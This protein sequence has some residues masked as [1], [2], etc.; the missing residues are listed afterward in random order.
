V[1]Y[2]SFLL[3]PSP[4]SSS[5]FLFLQKKGG[6]MAGS[7]GMA[8]SCTKRVHEELPAEGRDHGRLLRWEA[9]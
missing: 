7:R 6:S 4:P 3:L 5:L 1:K 2:E 9:T 8:F